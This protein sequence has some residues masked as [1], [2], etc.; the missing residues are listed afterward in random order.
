MKKYIFIIIFIVNL[1][2]LYSQDVEPTK[3]TNFT[4][5]AQ[6]HFMLGWHWGAHKSLSFALGNNQYDA[7]FYLKSLKTG[8]FIDVSILG[9]K[10][11]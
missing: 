11:S 7:M 8:T 6:T 3:Q 5:P 4:P 10:D 9:L 1:C 2:Y